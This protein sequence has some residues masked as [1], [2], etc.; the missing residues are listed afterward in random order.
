MSGKYRN[1]GITGSDGR[2]Y[3]DGPGHGFGYNAGTLWPSQRFSS[4]ADVE[5]ATRCCNVA[6]QEGYEAAQRDIRK[7][8]GLK[9]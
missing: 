1:P 4:E 2:L 6:Y 8:L 7:A 9:P 3:V 5:A